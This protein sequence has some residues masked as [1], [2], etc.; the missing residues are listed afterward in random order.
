MSFGNRHKDAD[1]REA[2][3]VIAAQERSSDE[4][5]VEGEAVEL[6]PQPDVYAAV[7]PAAAFQ[8]PVAFAPPGPEPGAAPFPAA[9]EPVAVVAA[10]SQ[11]AQVAALGAAGEAFASGHGPAPAPAWPDGVQELAAERPEVV[12]GA[13]FAGGILAAMILRRLGN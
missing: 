4:P 9:E 11:P 10:G 7:P 3:S 13:A 6:P 1:P 12:V 5:V 2:D 8:P